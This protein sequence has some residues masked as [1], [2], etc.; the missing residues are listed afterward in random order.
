MRGQTYSVASPPASPA[1]TGRVRRTRTSRSLAAIAAAAGLAVG[2]AGCHGTPVPTSIDV[3]M[4]CVEV[5]F[6]QPGDPLP[7][8]TMHVE[9]S[10]PTWADTGHSLPLDHL[11]VT[12]TPLPDGAFEFARVDTT[13]IEPF[14]QSFDAPYENTFFGAAAPDG[15]PADLGRARAR[16][17]GR[18]GSVATVDRA[19][20]SFVNSATSPTHGASCTP[21]PGEPT[22]LATIELRQPD[23]D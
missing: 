22:R 20:V 14:R 21:K 10:A 13:G 17:A 8:E 4:S 18:V 23:S 11:T 16:A 3:T 7:D 19:S 6:G 15:E 1:G 12:G 9:L 2:L 5:V